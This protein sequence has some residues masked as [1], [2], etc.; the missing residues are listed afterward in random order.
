MSSIRLSKNKSGRSRSFQ[1][2]LVVAGFGLLT[3][4]PFYVWIYYLQLHDKSP[5]ALAM[6]SMHMSRMNIF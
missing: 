3:F 5:A 2:A 4:I 6:A 1:L